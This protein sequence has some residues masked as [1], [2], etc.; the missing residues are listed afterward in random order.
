MVDLKL[1]KEQKRAVEWKRGPLMI[2]A[3]AGTGKTT[4]ITERVKYLTTS[5][6]AT[7]KEILALTFTQKAAQ[8]M[9]ERVDIAMPY[10]YTQMWISTFHTFCDRILRNEALHIGLDPKF[11]LMTQAE[12]TQFIRKHL[13]EFSFNYFAPLGNP[14]KFVGGILQHFSRLQDEDILPAEYLRWANSKSKVKKKRVSKDEKIE[15]KKWLELAHA[16]KKYD[17]LKTREGVMDFGDLITKA[18]KLF[19]DRP[20]ILGQYQKQFK[21]MLVDEY[22]DTNIA[23]NELVKLLAGKTGNITVVLDD[24]QAI[25]RWRG[26]AV[27]N[28]LQ[29]RQAFPKTKVISLIKNYR[30]AQEILDKAYALIQHNNPDRLEVKEKVDKKLIAQKKIKAEIGFFH[31]DRVENEAEVVAKKIKALIDEGYDFRDIAILVRANNH[32]EPFTRALGRTGMPHQ[33]LGPGRLFKQPEIIDLIAYLKVLCDFEDS[34]AFCRLISLDHFQIDG[35]DLVRIGNYARRR[36]LSF[37]EAVERIDD[38]KVAD[39]AKKKLVK[40]MKIIKKHLKLVRRETAGQLLYYFLE[41]TG[42]LTTLLNPD[43]A[44]GEKKAANISKF[45]DKLKT[46]EVDHEDATARAVVDWIELS[47]ELG[48]SPLAANIDWTGINAVNILTVHSAKGLEFPVVFLVNLVDSRFPTIERREPIPIPEALIKEELPEGDYHEQEERRLF[49]VGMTRAMDKLFF[50]AA[51][52]Y[53]EAKREKKL[54]PFIFEALGDEAV[55][56]EHQADKGEQLSFL[57]YAKPQLPAIS[58]QPLHID[59]LSYSQINTFEICPLH[60]KLKY[61]LK[62]PTPPSVA[63][64]FGTSIHAALKD[65]YSKPQKPT[66]KRVEEILKQNWVVEGYASKSHEARSFKKGREMILNYLKKGFNPKKIPLALEQP[67]VVPLSGKEPLKIGG[68]IDRIDKKGKGIEIIDYKTGSKV[69]TQREVDN[70][71]QLTFYAL[72]ATKIPEPPFGKKPEEITLSFHYLEEGEKVTTRRSAKQLK[73]AEEEIFEWKKKIEESDFACS[74]HY[75][76]QTGCEYSMFCG[77]V[78]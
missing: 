23:Q 11:K 14:T 70:N 62:V 31:Q 3:G 5:K 7:P 2:V 53:G 75:L 45:F 22:Q 37:F 17:E 57:E 48:E 77:V 33:F 76:C 12:T 56:A 46:Y 54:S 18:L 29:F 15:T 26:A 49:Y 47:S 19:R 74:N 24:D 20:N 39:K 38:I 69:P 58:Y 52:Y 68:Q 59:F 10:G 67:F 66:A 71:L 9:E 55:A 61:I 41:E 16:Y 60:Y 25:Y 36:N 13:F 72:A 8:E 43:T 63:Q 32:A 40:L 4:T 50:S 65:F 51:N 64:S 78:L 42:L 28:A 6:L 34:V 27:S 21:Y 1:N 73:E 44:E 30:S 35:R